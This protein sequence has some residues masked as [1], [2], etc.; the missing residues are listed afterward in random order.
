[1]AD[2]LVV[3]ANT[4]NY[5]VQH[6]AGKVPQAVA[7]ATRLGRFVDDTL[8]RHPIA[9]NEHIQVEYTQ[10]ANPEFV[11]DWLKHRWQCV[12]ALAQQVDPVP[13]PRNVTQ[14]LRTEYGLQGMGRDRRYLETAHACTEH[15]LVSHD[16]DFRRS[17]A[18]KP[19]QPE[20]DVYLRRCE[21]AIGVMY[22]DEA[23]VKYSP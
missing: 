14:H 22:V 7:Q 13:L 11:K 4:L 12:P 9:L 23:V 21:C 17:V 6:L 3:D 2:P 19:R 20:M 1:M 5:V 16:P 10:T 15:C 8:Q 18:G